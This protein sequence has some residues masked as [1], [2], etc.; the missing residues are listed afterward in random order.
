M[1][2]IRVDTN[3]DSLRAETTAT[4][5]DP[6][7]LEGY[8]ASGDGGGGE[9]YWDASSTAADDGGMVFQTNQKAIN[10][11]TTGT[12][13]IVIQT[14]AA[15]GFTTG[16]Q[17][18][19][20]GVLGNTAANGSWT[21]TVVDS[22]HFSLNGSTGNGAYTSGGYASGP[23]RWRRLISGVQI[24]VKWFGANPSSSDNAAVIQVAIDYCAKSSTIK[25]IF[26]PGG[27]YDV[28]STLNIINDD[29]HFAAAGIQLHG[30]PA[31]RTETTTGSTIRWMG[32]SSSVPLI[33][34]W[35]RECSLYQISFTAG[36]TCS[37]FIDATKGEG[38]ASICTS[39]RFE[40][41]SFLG[42]SLTKFGVVIGDDTGSGFPNNCEE[43]HFANC[44]F[45]NFT[46]LTGTFTAVSGTPTFTST[47]HGLVNGD[48]VFVSNSGGALPAGLAAATAYYVVNKAT[49]TFQL[50]TAYGGTE[51]T[52][53]SNGTGTQTFTSLAA[54]V[55]I[56]NNTFQSKS[57]SF[58]NCGFA[59][60]QYG[61]YCVA[62]GFQM[63]K[64]GFQ[65]L[66]TAAIG[67]V[68]T[69]SIVI[70]SG[71]LENCP[72]FLL[73][74]GNDGA[75]TV[76]GGR[77]AA[78][79]VHADGKFI[80][81]GMVG[82]VTL[83]GCTF[84]VFNDPT[85]RFE[86]GRS[87]LGYPAPAQLIMRGCG[88]PNINPASAGSG[89]LRYS[90]ENCVYTPGS[91]YTSVPN[92]QAV[93]GVDQI[94]DFS[95]ANL[96]TGYVTKSVAGSSDVDL[97]ATADN[98]TPISY[99]ETIELTGALTG[100][101]KVKLAQLKWAKNIKN[102]TTGAFTLTAVTTN[103]ASTGVVVPQG[104]AQRL[105]SDGTN[106]YAASG[107]SNATIPATRTIATTAPLTGGGDLSAD[108]TLAVS[109]AT[110]SAVGAVKLAT[111]LAGTATA[112]VVQQLTGVS[113]AVAVPSATDLKWN[114]SSGPTVGTRDSGL[115]LN[116]KV[117]TANN[118]IA[119]ED[120]SNVTAF[121]G[122][123]SGNPFLSSF[124]T[125]FTIDGGG[126]NTPV[127]LNGTGAGGYSALMHG[128]TFR[129][130][131]DNTGLGFFGHTP[132]AQQ[133]DI[134]ALTDN[135]GGTAD[136]TIQAL[137]NPADSPATADAL[138]DDLVAN[139]IP[140]LRNDIAD[141][142]EQCNALRAALRA[143]GLMA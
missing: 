63:F 36:T 106:V 58:I 13:P 121:F 11:A 69:E 139:L 79:A 130:K 142:T 95:R 30:D 50:S 44:A 49:N 34:G 127:R 84:D 57:H 39:W 5:G 9:L 48:I 66:T 3:V 27:T 15:H 65:A 40:D 41:I 105:F 109:D 137:P 62:G 88:L 72:R 90:I 93:V 45:S 86:V 94:H 133:A 59:A 100:N 32:A 131:A 101:I 4:S 114:G 75:V 33:K 136:N 92:V 6:A 61:I 129:V 107:P 77:W 104:A 12:P 38:T 74:T 54:G 112:P 83:D 37:R 96:I 68:N 24:S 43:F 134:G 1:P 20:Q 87:G 29:A 126:A 119:F 56:P 73:G 70:V 141:L 80:K 78:T 2:G 125:T 99:Y 42:N 111:D 113:N 67:A 128:G 64:P 102:S 120:G 51:I 14:S 60:S 115:G 53:A 18:G 52:V 108:R 16:A 7:L 110:T 47:A 35:S 91:V 89:N 17:I 135:S 31:A 97:T 76:H 132:A 25:T 117:R 46:G 28:Q 19:I 98:T 123:N 140:A 103:G 71:Q 81:W 26:F 122:W 143:Y 85:V 8:Y 22:T 82:P 138:R 23:G 10:G 118:S 116:F 124:G 55:H 21:I